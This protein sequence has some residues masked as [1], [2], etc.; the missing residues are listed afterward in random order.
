MVTKSTSG[1]IQMKELSSREFDLV[2]GGL[3]LSG[4]RTSD[5]VVDGNSLQHYL[6][7]Y[8]GVM[9]PVMWAAAQLH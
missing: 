4:R 3:D 9:G 1:R 8:G 2:A 5:N 7:V 6:D